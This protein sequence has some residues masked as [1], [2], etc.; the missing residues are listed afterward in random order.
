MRGTAAGDKLT[1]SAEDLRSFPRLVRVLLFLL[2]VAAGIAAA[3]LIGQG[4]LLFTLA[5]AV[6][7]LAALGVPVRAAFAAGFIAGVA[8]VAKAV[9]VAFGLEPL[10]IGEWLRVGAFALAWAAVL[11][12]IAQVR[13]YSRLAVAA[14]VVVAVPVFIALAVPLV[15]SVD[16]VQ[17]SSVYVAMRDGVRIATD[18]YLPRGFQTQR[19]PAIL[20]QTRYFRR[21]ELRLPYKL[22][23]G[24]TS[25]DVRRFVTNGYAY[26]YVDARGSGASFGSR[27]QEWSDDEI[28]DGGEVVDWI[29]KQPWSSGNVGA[30]GI[31]YDGTAAE[32]LLANHHPA[33]KACAP[34][35]SLLDAYAD[36]GFPGGVH[37]SWFTEIWSSYN[38]ALDR[39]AL[40]EKLQGFQRRII[41]GVAPV[42]GH[43]ALLTSALRE[44][45]SNYSVRAFTSSITFRDDAGVRGL[46]MERM[47]PYAKPEIA[48][49]A[50][51]FYSYSGWYDGA[52]NGAA[53]ARFLT[54]R[55]PGSRLIL[56]PWDHGGRQNV[57]PHDAPGTPVFDQA[58]ELLRFFDFH[59]KGTDN[60]FGRERAV[61]Y[62]TMG[63]EAW[64]ESTTW[65]PAAE[66]RTLHF[67]SEHALANAMPGV[68]A[69]WDEYKVDLTAT[70]GTGSRWRSYFNPDMTPIGYPD[71]AQQDSKLLTYTSAP[72]AEDWEITGHPTITLWIASSAS[73]GQFFAYLEDI[74]PDGR[75]TY[76]T[77]GLIRG[78][79]RAINPAPY[80]HPDPSH[81]FR[82]N[83]GQSLK[84]E[85]PAEIAF[86][87][88]PTSYLVRKGHSV[89]VAL[90]GADR[91][92]F[93]PLPGDAPTWRVYRDGAHPSRIRLP[94]VSGG[95]GD[96]TSAATAR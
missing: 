30:T 93:A 92:Q 51:P 4:S 23:F 63:A 28:R 34:R 18:V 10:H 31:S 68:S 12:V 38:D 3:V 19:L 71:R 76:I 15:R 61:R 50:V 46:T 32:M 88:L 21:T 7:A 47:S 57:S 41:K 70:T 94:I 1:S 79:H 56:G 74:S 95:A 5:P 89:R 49:S 16:T 54:Y 8:V 77:E 29:V 44:H 6:M 72:L 48:H 86:V 60:G 75:V 25:A 35:F 26:V 40:T 14:L 81:S 27:T 65:P 80:W 87:L 36:I 52:Y 20:H 59:L 13:R 11:A 9:A 91:D 2:V 42:D 96:S 69:M 24:S 64:R 22:L 73:D 58:G 53:I 43:E 37:Y 62:Y 85:E 66:I 83:D 55:I 39:N 17:R 90:A 78:L 33:V 84:E 45:A 67:A 82:R